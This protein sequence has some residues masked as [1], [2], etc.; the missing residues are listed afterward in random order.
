MK[1]AK[2]LKTLEYWLDWIEKF[3]AWVRASPEHV[4][5]NDR[6]D[7]RDVPYKALQALS[8]HFKEPYHDEDE[9]HRKWVYIIVEHGMS[10]THL[11][12]KSPQRKFT[13]NKLND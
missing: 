11:V 4:Y 1:T 13:Y 6:Y 3:K 2:N 8:A 10:E 5:T 7:I 9:K 12:F